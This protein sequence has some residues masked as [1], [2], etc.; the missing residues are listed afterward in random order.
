VVDAFQ[1]IAPLFRQ[2]SDEVHDEGPA[3]GGPAKAGH[4]VPRRTA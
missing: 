4:Y 3:A 2:V 1:A